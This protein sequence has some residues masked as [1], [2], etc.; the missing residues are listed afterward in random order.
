MTSQTKC[1][2]VSVLGLPNAGKSTLV[3]ALVGAKISIVSRKV[4]T[5]RTRVLGIV[6]HDKAQIVLIDTPGIFAPKKPL[7]KAMVHAAW[8]T[9]AEADLLLHI[10][11]AAQKDA[12][13]NNRLIVDKLPRDKGCI[14]VL[15][16]TDKINKEALLK[17]AQDFTDQYSYAAVFMI[18]AL[19]K[20]GL[21]DVLAW[22]AQHL[23]ESPYLFNEDDI[24]DMPMR[25][26]AAEIT[27]EKIYDR[28]HEELPYAIFIETENWEEF[29][30]GSVKVDQIIYVQRDSQKGIVLGKG[31]RQIK[32][33]GE[34]ARHDLEEILG[35][36][37]HLKLFVKV[38]ENWSERSEIYRRLGLEWQD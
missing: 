3:N 6:I 9:L 4:Q 8:N 26:L 28:L 10:V 21:Q 5:T 16:K 38:Q 27:R 14:L 19:K 1:G 12:F 11:D 35:R 36:R 24:T 32:E 31:G 17:L 22:L 37:V 7:E 18:S 25:M 15:N 34:M 30:N 29:D 20:D 33:L 23:P 2:F 13:E